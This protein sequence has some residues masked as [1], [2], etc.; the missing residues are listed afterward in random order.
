MNRFMY[1]HINMYTVHTHAYLYVCVYTSAHKFV[2]TFKKLKHF[3]NSHV[4]VQFA[5]QIISNFV[6]IL[7]HIYNN[8]NN[9]M[10]KGFM[11]KFRK[12]KRRRYEEKH[13]QYSNNNRKR[14]H[15]NYAEMWSG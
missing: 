13:Q 9:K 2:Y 10:C 11:Y 14:P 5:F 7:S 3:T 6:V 8:N 4:N 12:I 1:M 15:T